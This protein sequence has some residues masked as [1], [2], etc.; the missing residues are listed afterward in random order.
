MDIDA[1]LT[2]FGN[3]LLNKPNHPLTVA[4]TKLVKNNSQI[5][6]GRA[7]LDPSADAALLSEEELEAKLNDPEWVYKN[8]GLYQ[9]FVE[10][11][12]EQVGKVFDERGFPKPKPTGGAPGK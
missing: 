5:G 1:F 8:S 6:A 2:E 7:L 4:M 3:T 12:Y 10:T 11:T 9:R